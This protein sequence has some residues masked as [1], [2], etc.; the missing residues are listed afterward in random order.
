MRTQFKNG[1]LTLFSDGRIDSY[2]AAEVEQE[3][4]NA[5][6]A[7]PGA[8]LVLD[9]EELEY[10]SSA[11]LRVLMKLRKQSEKTIRVENV[12]QEV[13]DIFQVTGFTDL[14]EVHKKLREISVDGCEIIG[15]GSFG[16][17]YR[18]D[19]ETIVKVYREGVGLEQL[20][21]ES[22]CA[23]VA[24]VHGIP[25]AIAYDTVKV[26]NC[27]G[28]VYE[29]LDAVTVG[30]AVTSAPSRAEELGRKMGA[31]LRQ[32]H[33]TELEPGVL[34]R[35]SDRI[36]D[37]IDYLEQ[38]HLSHEDAKL[39]RQVVDA[40][41]EKNTLLH[42]DF[43]EGNVMV[44]DGELMLIDLDS[45]CL[46]NPLYDMLFSYSLHRLGAHRSKELARRSLN[47][48]PEMIPVIADYERRAYLDTE[49]S[50]DLER[51]L[52][53][54]DLF[55]SYRMLIVI[56]AEGANRAMTP[57]TV[58]NIKEIILPVFRKNA[59]KMIQAVA[60]L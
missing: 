56:A 9:A 49:N 21:E 53:I 45:I 50:A 37:Q 46:G 11:G 16:I 47:L 39:L 4:M 44:R 10:I 57:V 38:R 58:R 60:Q 13:F 22:R 7:V 3:A 31:L 55:L 17:V 35:M 25:T 30:K 20:Q 18:I 14:L 36:R 29:M 5:V 48:E 19:P 34:P 41:P 43:Q 24:F 28:N 26:G 40:I 59:P 15:Q 6:G 33:Q 42:G 52:K 54:M 32:L 27:F 51:Y 2:N 23:T 1:K 8:E 12:S